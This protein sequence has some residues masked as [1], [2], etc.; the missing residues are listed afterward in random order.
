MD[1]KEEQKKKDLDLSLTMQQKFNFDSNSFD[2]EDTRIYKIKRKQNIIRSKREKELMKLKNK[3]K[4]KYHITLSLL[5]VLLIIFVENLAV[6]ISTNITDKKMVQKKE[7]L[8]LDENIVFLGDSITE[9][10]NV[11]EYYENYHVVNS[12]KGGNSTIDLLDNLD[13]RVYQYN[14]S[15]LFLL[16]GTND[17]AYQYPKDEIYKNIVKIV[18]EIKK[19]K[20]YTK[21][22]VESIYPINNSND[23]KISRKSVKYRT[24]E[25]INYI[26]N[27]LSEKYD[28]SDVTFI[29]VNKELLDN[30]GLLDIE[31]T[32]DGVHI[33]EKGYNKITSVL[34]PYIKE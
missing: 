32:V 25:I 15:K 16:I 28:D 18:D 21:I 33:S 27:K 11:N 8:L 17:M 34:L 31:Y 26:N 14:P 7:E 13:S 24:N 3:Y 4:K 2:E 20:S 9:L 22:Y 23:P 5:I 29:D 12:G 1:K 19:N 6:F 10:Y 30:N